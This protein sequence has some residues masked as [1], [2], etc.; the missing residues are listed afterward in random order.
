MEVTLGQ[1]TAEVQDRTH[2][3]CQ[4]TIQFTPLSEE[5]WG[6]VL[7]LFQQQLAGAPVI[8]PRVA[9]PEN[10]PAFQ[11]LC[12]LLLPANHRALRASCSCCPT[13]SVQN[14]PALQTVYRQL[15]AMLDEEP[16]L[17]LRL[18][19]REWQQV[20]QT[21]QKRRSSEYGPPT[22]PPGAA[23]RLVAQAESTAGREAVVDGDALANQLSNFWGSRKQMESVQHHIV[24]PTVD[25][26][27]L[28]RLG[29]LPDELG[30]PVVDQQLAML[31][32]A[33]S[34]EAEALA[35]DLESGSDTPGAVPAQQ[36]R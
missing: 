2:G 3:L 18:R 4:V 22:A 32:R 31:Y 23:P 5:I 33:I 27:I 10:D 26:A 1:V 6:R 24:S 14:C 25:L 35:Y 17:L 29:P 28:R 20:V 19:G 7:A 9:F 15:G 11:D 16:V 34:R 13:A 36:M 12:T 21:L 8:E 30:D